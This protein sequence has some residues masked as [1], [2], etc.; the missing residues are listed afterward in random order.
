MKE[1]EEIPR[2]PGVPIAPTKGVSAVFP[3][4]RSPTATGRRIRRRFR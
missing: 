1:L 3:T 4:R 2:D